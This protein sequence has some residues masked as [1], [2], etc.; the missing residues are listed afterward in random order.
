VHAWL[1]PDTPVQ[2]S[3]QASLGDDEL[4]AKT[5]PQ[6]EDWLRGWRA[7]RT[8]QSWAA[9]AQRD[10]T[11]HYIRPSR[12]RAVQSRTLVR[13]ALIIREVVRARKRELIRM[14]SAMTLAFDD[15][16]GYKLVRFRVDTLKTT[17][18][19]SLEESAAPTWKTIAAEGIVGCIQC[20]RGSTLEDFADDYAQ[21]AAREV[22]TLI[23]R[24]CTP[25]SMPK[26]VGLFDHIVASVR[27]IVADGA[28]QKTA[29][30]L[31][32]SLPNIVLVT[33]DPGHFV[34]IAC[35][36][37][38]LRT[39][40]F[41]AQHKRL[42]TNPDALLKKITFSDCMQAR[43]EACQKLVVSA[44]GAQGGGVTSVMKH[45]SYAPHRFESWVEPRRRYACI[46][47][48][49]ALLLAEVAG[50]RRRKLSERESAEKCLQAMTPQELLETGFASDWGEVCMRFSDLNPLQWCPSS[51][52]NIS[53]SDHI[54]M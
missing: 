14:C 15:R 47:H 33:R 49:V 11:E 39:G 40:R 2:L 7:S 21:R 18:A 32:S 43:L 29:A 24:L 35:R 28:L 23:E 4:L 41:E 5:V 3:L 42:F 8:P 37:P 27:G 51:P 30:V 17:T 16:Q 12:V 54:I 6:P 53:G 19:A 13:M 22:M 36:D 31:R 9:A 44:N 38:L 45:F 50:D 20:L 34:R 1:R 25:K 10:E 26:D 52:C 46:L 48:A